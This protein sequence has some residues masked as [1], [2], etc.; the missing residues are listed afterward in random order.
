MVPN[1]VLKDHFVVVLIVA[2]L[3]K[4]V[5]SVMKETGGHISQLICRIKNTVILEC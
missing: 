1:T 5:N 2:E 4:T 3:I